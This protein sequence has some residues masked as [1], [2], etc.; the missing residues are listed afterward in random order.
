MSN[1]VHFDLRA[2]DDKVP[3]NVSSV[4]IHPSVTTIGDMAFWKCS[5]LTS[6]ILP[7][8]ITTI[9]AYAFWGCIAL[10]QRLPNGINNNANTETWLQQRLDNLPL[11]QSLYNATTLTKE[12]LLDLIHLHKA[13][14]TTTDA[15]G[16]T[17]LHVLCANP[18]VGSLEMIQILTDAKPEVALMTTVCGHTPLM[19]L[20]QLKGFQL[21]EYCHE[22]DGKTGTTT[23]S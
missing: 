15:M 16:M 17:P 7:D 21:N 12:I 3:K 5:N 9:G 11:H 20:L 10:K 6:L 4:T 23:T 13:R 19:L 18:N 22:E 2:N 1:N 14:L 8:S